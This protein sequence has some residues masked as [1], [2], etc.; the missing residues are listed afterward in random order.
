MA[1]QRTFPL[2]RGKVMRV[3]QVDGCGAPV[4]GVASTVVSKG[5]VSVA[6]APD[7]TEAEPIE[8]QNA[9][10]QTCARDPGS[11][12]MNGY[13][14][15]TT[16][17]NVNPALYALMTAQEVVTDGAGEAVGFRVNTKVDLSTK[18]YAL[19]VW[20][21]VPGEACS[22]GAGAYGYFLVPFVQAGVVGEVT[23]ENGAVTF[24]VTGSKTK[25]G[26]AWGVGAY[27]VVLDASDAAGPLLDPLDPND[28]LH[29]QFT[30]V[31]PPAET[32][33]AVAYPPV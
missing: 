23:I 5:F 1:G 30:E 26:N 8:V 28:H 20:A 25:D 19:E 11:P 32:D 21:G 6:L 10:G 7:I 12:S 13:T 29:V 33:G 24:T 22:G 27:D 31:A 14:V 15:E 2:I 4:A 18:A 16:F 17:C 9:D 3:T